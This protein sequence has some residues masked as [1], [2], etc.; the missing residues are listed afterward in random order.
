[1]TRREL[2]EAE[3]AALRKLL[4]AAKLEVLPLQSIA[5]QLTAVA[6]GT[7]LAIAASPSK[8]LD[9]SLRLGERLRKA[10]YEVVVH[11]AAHMV[12]GR[13]HLQS[14]LS[15]LASAGIDRIF[16]VGGDAM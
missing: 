3:R 16:V 12:T 8:G 1:M 9:A 5:S 11:L 15:S 2:T 6:P 13:E 4:A 7:T 14:L 10:G